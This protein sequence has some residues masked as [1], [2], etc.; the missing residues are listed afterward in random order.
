MPNRKAQGSSNAAQA[1]PLL[2]Q[3]C[4]CCPDATAVCHDSSSD[5]ESHEDMLSMSM[6]QH[7]NI[8][9][10][11]AQACAPSS[12]SA[13]GYQE[14]RRRCVEQLLEKLSAL[15]PLRQLLPKQQWP[16]PHGTSHLTMAHGCTLWTL[17]LLWTLQLNFEGAPCGWYLLL[18]QQMQGLSACSQDGLLLP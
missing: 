18:G 5:W 13:G 4:L 17:V 3:Q 16:C 15:H 8:C 7:G 1:E 11:A 14:G 6:Q 10:L 2:Q 12:P 9:H